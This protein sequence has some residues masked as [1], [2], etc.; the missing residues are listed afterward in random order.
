MREVYGLHGDNLADVTH[1]LC[2]EIPLSLI[3]SLKADTS[4]MYIFSERVG[5]TEEQIVETLNRQ[6]SI[7]LRFEPSEPQTQ[8]F[9]PLDCG[10]KCSGEVSFIEIN[11]RNK[12]EK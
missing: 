8:S 11:Q 3:M 10:V 7:I 2:S 4:L 5:N 9:F 12:P 1:F 6:T